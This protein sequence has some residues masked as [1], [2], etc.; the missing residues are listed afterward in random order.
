MKRL[1]LKRRD[2][3]RWQADQ[4]LPDS[5][6]CGAVREIE[7]GLVD[8]DLGG[9]LFKKRIASPGSGKRGGYR[10]LL[11]MRLGDRAI[12]LHG[13]AKNVKENITRDEAGALR[14]TGRVL[15]DLPQSS[16]DAALAAGILIEV[17][18]N[19]RDH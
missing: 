13:F 7:A 5:A 9:H 12:F 19:E 16:L 10:T 1:I 8:A 6:L 4:R 2:F 18:C 11:S 3:A 14:Y 15:L 17:S